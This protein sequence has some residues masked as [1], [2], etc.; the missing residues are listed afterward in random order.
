MLDISAWVGA[1]VPGLGGIETEG[2][3]LAC[4]GAPEP[5]QIDVAAFYLCAESCVQPPTVWGE[6]GGGKMI[7]PLLNV[8]HCA[9]CCTYVSLQLYHDLEKY[10]LYRWGSVELQSSDTGARLT[11]GIWIMTLPPSKYT[12]SWRLCFSICKVGI[13]AEQTSIVCGC[14]KY[15]KNCKVLRAFAVY[16]IR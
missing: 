11:A 12:T 9:G 6:V 4:P 16:S 1:L 14:E 10:V 5:L 7:Q 2:C 15:L 13:I 8:R 3:F